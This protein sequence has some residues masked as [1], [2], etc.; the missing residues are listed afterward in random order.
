M[1]Y[2]RSQLHI[3]YRF[4]VLQDKEVREKQSE[5]IE[6]GGESVKTI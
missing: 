1:Y 3:S 6:N 5:K 2:A 4:S